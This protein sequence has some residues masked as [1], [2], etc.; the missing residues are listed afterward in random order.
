M[1]RSSKR[2]WEAARTFQ[3]IPAC[4][5]DLS[6]P[7]YADLLFGKGVQRASYIFVSSIINNQMNVKF[8]SETR[9]IKMTHIT[10]R[11]RA[12][13]WCFEAK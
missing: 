12:C 7:Q 2:V 6:E 3:N 10:L 5:S 1:S 8:C 4:P 13:K 11:V 9:T